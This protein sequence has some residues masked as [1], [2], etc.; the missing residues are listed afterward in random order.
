MAMK[1]VNAQG[2]LVPNPSFEVNSGCPGWPQLSLATGWINPTPTS[3]DYHHACDSTNTYGVPDNTAGH[4]YARTGVAYAGLV[5][6]T[7]SGREYIQIQ[8]TDTL[9]AGEWYC[10]SYFIS[11]SEESGYATKAPQL[12]FSNAS[13]SSSSWMNLNYPPHIANG[14]VVYDTAQWVEIAGNYIA[15]GGE[16]CITI[17]NFNNNANTTYDAVSGTNQA[18]YYYIDDVSVMRRVN[19]SAGLDTTICSGDSTSIGSGL[20]P[21][22]LMY[23]WLPTIGLSDSTS[24]NPWAKPIITTTY[25]LT[26]SDTGNRY[27]E[28]FL[29]DSVTITVA[30]C[31][32]PNPLSVPTLIKNS[33][34]FYVTSLPENSSLEIFDNRGRLIYRSENYQNDFAVIQL[35]ADLY[36]YRLTFSDQTTQR[37]KFCVVK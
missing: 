11:L 28:G 2:N 8:L 25:Y 1:S 30:D 21:S 7:F 31:T 19:A 34:V 20:L 15:T 22:D 5:S 13:I 37:G 12:H 35:A 29:V 26:I 14:L 23:Q 3:P 9:E 17:G 6:F 33:E 27:C 10:V 18:A 32:P 36:F 24:S 16:R 4:Q